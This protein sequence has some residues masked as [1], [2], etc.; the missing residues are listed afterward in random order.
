MITNL[1]L[2][3]AGHTR[4]RIARAISTDGA[5]APTC[6][7]PS[8]V[9]DN[10]AAGAIEAG[11]VA[12]LT[13]LEAGATNVVFAPVGGPASVKAGPVLT[14][15]GMPRMVKL[16]VSDGPGVERVPQASDAQGVT[17][18]RLLVALAAYRYSRQACLVVDAG[19]T[20][21]IDYVNS[22][23]VLQGGLIGPGLAASIRAWCETTGTPLSEAPTVGRR[24]RRTALA[25]E[26]GDA[27]LLGVKTAARGLVRYHLERVAEHAGVYPRVVATGDDAALL[28]EDDDVVETV[29]PE[30]AMLGMMESWRVLAGIA[31][32]ESRLRSEDGEQDE[33]E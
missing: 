9:V 24:A 32:E 22:Y 10:G 28:F 6:L 33:D 25:V 15:A 16:G 21:S 11:I 20:V 7:Q 8:R 4:T 1:V 19:A 17:L 26:Q 3:L 2:V 14:R 13:G 23:G 27:V 5:F 18:D 30:L 12:A 29:V 31:A